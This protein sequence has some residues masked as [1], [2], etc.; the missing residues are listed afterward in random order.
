MAR[1]GFV[2]PMMPARPPAGHQHGADHDNLV[3][4]LTDSS[5]AAKVSPTSVPATTTPTMETPTSPATRAMALLIADAISGVTLVAHRRA[6]P[7]RGVRQS[8]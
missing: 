8:C 3:E 1:L 2:M 4:S 6:R 5:F 7:R